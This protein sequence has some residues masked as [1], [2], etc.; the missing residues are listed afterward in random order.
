MPCDPGMFRDCGWVCGHSDKPQQRSPPTANPYRSTPVLR[1][2]AGI[3][4]LPGSGQ[5]STASATK[6][7]NSSPTGSVATDQC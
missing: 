5:A 4:A 2:A 6:S 3:S 7:T 1:H